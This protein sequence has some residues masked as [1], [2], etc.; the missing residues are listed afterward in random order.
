VVASRPNALAEESLV[1]S[2]LGLGAVVKRS[3]ALPA[4]KRVIIFRSSSA[5]V[6]FVPTLTELL[7]PSGK[8]D[9]EICP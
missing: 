3:T 9:V 5:S 8:Y 7:T 2:T 6:E 1:Y 4:G